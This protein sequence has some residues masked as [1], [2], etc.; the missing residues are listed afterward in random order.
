MKALPLAFLLLPLALGCG[1][2]PNTPVSGFTLSAAPAT[3]SLT[4]GGAAQAITVAATA[5]SGFSGPVN[6]TLSGLPAGVTASPSTLSITPG[7]LRQ[8]MLT[9]TGAPV[10]SAAKIT[11]TGTA[12]AFISSATATLAVTPGVTMAAL[13]AS[14][15]DFGGNLVGATQ[16]KPVVTVTNTGSSDLSLSPTLTGDASYALVPGGSC[17]S[18]LAPGSSCVE[19]VSYT[20]TAPSGMTT[21][22]ATLNFGFGDV[23]AGTPQTVAL[24]GASAALPSGAVT[25]T[26]NPQVA[27]YSITLPFPG[28]ITVSFGPDITYGH[29]TWSRSTNVAGGR[30]NLLVAGMLPNTTYHM[31]ASVQFT[32]GQTATDVD[33]TFTTKAPLLTPNL[34]VTTSPGLTPQSGVEELTFVAGGT[35]GLVIT[36]LLGKVLWSYAL[37]S[38][39]GGYAIEGAKLLENGDFLLAIGQGSTFSLS[40]ASTG[41][42]VIVEIREIDLAGNIVR[43]ISTND[44]SDE[45]QD[46]GY[47][48]TLQQFHHDVTPL[49]NGHWLVL[50]NTLKSFT[51]LPGYPGVTNVLGDVVIDL[52]RNLQPVWVWNEFD[53]FDVNRHPMSFPDWTHSNAVI[54]SPSDGNIIVSMRH[55]NWVVKVGYHDGAGAGDILWR[56]G[57][58]GD[59]TLSG[60]TDPTDWQYAQ[61]YPSLFSANSSGVFSLGLM[62]NGNDRIFPAGV[63]CGT[64]GAPACQYTTI[65]VFQLDEGAKTAKLVFH[66]ILPTSLYSFFGGNTDL[67]ANGNIEYDLAGT[68]G[69]S[70]DVFEVTPT[71]TPQTVW[72]LHSTGANAYRGYRIP[73]LYPGVQW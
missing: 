11:V 45:L 20:P 39:S 23:P 16:T 55:Q 37:P 25:A 9:A 66:Q 58:D 3:I 49:P 7:Q 13:S 57:A 5:L 67:L 34:T 69:G 71:S 14:S 15:F 30:V 73:S 52:D 47:G 18:T 70:S 40:G 4:N 46:A 50:A 62:D 56:L 41:Q 63:N 60:G 29:Q 22:T 19:N 48:L 65:P 72:H 6:L 38:D 54:Y 64:A 10:S 42:G 44:L 68:N 21:E 1:S 61:H 36:D 32:S 43:E 31:Q 35:K 51:D 53:H 2:H 8:I 27:L 26:N 12:G 33:H 59:F 28:S 17:G 24:S